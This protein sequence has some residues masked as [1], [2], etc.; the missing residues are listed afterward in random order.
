MNIFNS[1]LVLEIG[2]GHN[3]H[4]RTD[5]LCDK[6]FAPHDDRW[7][8]DLKTDARPIIIA[9]GE[10][11]PFP[12]NAV[13]YTI[14]SH[15]LEHT[16]D[17]AAFLLELQRVSKRG[18]IETPAPIADSLLEWHAH[19]WFCFVRSN[20][21]IIQKRDTDNFKGF[22][23]DLLHKSPEFDLFY[24]IYS[25]SIF[26]TRYEWEESVNFK[27]IDD[28]HDFFSSQELVAGIESMSREKRLFRSN[29]KYIG[30][31]IY[32]LFLSK[33]VRYKIYSQVNNIKSIPHHFR[34]INKKKINVYDLLVCPF[35]KSRLTSEDNSLICD[36]CNKK[37]QVKNNIPILL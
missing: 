22:F 14:C 20:A 2:S 15:V 31:Y 23:W 28:V 29:L 6:H 16:N 33:N 25:K 3:P 37:Y 13:D 34:R 11:L 7:D 18:Y 17:P 21:L 35:C 5:I 36:G 24:D 26:T 4:P 30:L 27:I 1:D 10:K 12:D 19:N 32:K 9:D 8:R